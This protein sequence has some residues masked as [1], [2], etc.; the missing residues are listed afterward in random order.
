LAAAEAKG[1]V[2]VGFLGRLDTEKSP[3][4]FIHMAALVAK[5][6]ANARFLVIGYG[7]LREPLERE[8]RRLGLAE[9]AL[10]FAGPLHAE[11]PEVLASLDIVVNPSLRAWSE[12][13]CIANIEAMASG[14]P[15]V[16]FGVGGTGEYLVHNENS[17]VVD[18]ATPEALAEAVL[19]LAVDARLRCRLGEQA[20]RT[21]VSNFTVGHQLRAYERLYL[22]L[23]SD[24]LKQES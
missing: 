5:T 9:D 22:G 3:G 20:R 2:W 1:C 14:V 19:R 13:F 23:M 8:A 15:V 17:L 10:V 24:Y 18:E 11:L 7:P 12:T 6:F 4:L 21:V 16:S